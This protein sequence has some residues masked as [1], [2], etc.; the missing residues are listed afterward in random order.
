MPKL[1]IEA[2]SI[3]ENSKGV[4]KYSYQL[5]LQLI[6]R[7]PSNWDI[8][9][10]HNTEFIPSFPDS[11]SR[12]KL[13][14]TSATSELDLGLRVVQRMINKFGIDI[15][16][17]PRDSVGKDYGLPTVT[18]CHDINELITNSQD[19]VIGLRR[20]ALNFIKEYFRVRAMR[21]SDHVVCNSEF[22]QAAVY[23][24]YGIDKPRTSIGYCGIDPRFY[25]LSIQVNNNLIRERYGVSKFI[26]IFATGDSRENYNILPEIILSL[27]ALG[28]E[29]CFIIAGVNHEVPYV[30][31]LN[32]ALS[33]S[34]LIYGKNY[35]FEDFLNESKFVNLVE[36]YTSADFYLELSLH[37][38]FGMQLAEAMSCGTTVIS[39][40]HSAL[41]EVASGYSVEIFLN[42]AVD[43]AQK[44]AE[45]YRNGEHLRNNSDQISFTRKF[46]WEDLGDS[47]SNKLISIYSKNKKS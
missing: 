10:L 41:S 45:A 35:L 13:I 43:I 19:K 28:L 46:S 16:L 31:D 15:L 40:S 29:P 25:T 9:I 42:S 3:E 34:G 47:I 22:T 26:L 1:L 18:I 36:L 21:R 7:M 11:T 39:P 20:Y 5:C 24:Y 27:K 32:D 33:K 6:K 44:I 4:G 30:R 17:R 38:G 23:K 14:P 2:L 37:E 8:Y 12:V